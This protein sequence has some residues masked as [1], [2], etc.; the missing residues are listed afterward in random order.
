MSRPLLQRLVAFDETGLTGATA[1]VVRL[2]VQRGAFP[3]GVDAVPTLGTVGSELRRTQRWRPLVVGEDADVVA[4]DVLEVELS[5]QQARHVRVRKR[6]GHS[7]PL[8]GGPEDVFDRV[9]PGDGVP[10][11]PGPP[12]TRLDIDEDGDAAPQQRAVH[13]DGEPA[14]DAHLL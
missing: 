11:G 2:P 14:D 8:I 13:V 4:L 7:H 5:L 3:L 6:R 9:R 10:D 12:R 1:E